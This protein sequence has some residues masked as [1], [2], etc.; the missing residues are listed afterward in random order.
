MRKVRQL[1]ESLLGWGG[2]K[3]VQD[4]IYLDNRVV[5]MRG[6]RTTTNV[7]ESG[8]FYV[9]K[10][11]NNN[12]EY[13]YYSKSRTPDVGDIVF[14]G[15]GA[16]NYVYEYNS[17]NDYIKSS[18]G[19]TYF[20]NG[21]DD[22][23][24]FSVGLT[25]E[26]V[27]LINI[28]GTQSDKAFTITIDYNNIV[29]NERFFF[30]KQTQCLIRTACEEVGP[31]FPSV[32]TTYTLKRIV[33]D[34]YDPNT[35]E[36]L[37]HQFVAGYSSKNLINDDY[38]FYNCAQGFYTYYCNGVKNAATSE[39]SGIAHPAKLFI[40]CPRYHRV[41]DVNIGSVVSIENP[42]PTYLPVDP[43]IFSGDSRDQCFG[44]YNQSFNLDN[45][46]N[47]VCG[48]YS[49]HYLGSF[50]DPVNQVFYSLIINLE[51][52]PI[53]VEIKSTITLGSNAPGRTY[54]STEKYPMGPFTTQTSYYLISTNVYDNIVT[55]RDELEWVDFDSGEFQFNYGYD[56][57]YLSG[58]TSLGILPDDNM[59]GSAYSAT[60][61]PLITNGTWDGRFKSI[62]SLIGSGYAN[63][64]I[65][66]TGA[67]FS[68]PVSSSSNIPR[69]YTGPKRI[70]TPT[71]ITTAGELA[72]LNG[73]TVYKE[74]DDPCYVMLIWFHSRN[75][76]MLSICLVSE[77][78]NGAAY[79]TSSSS[80]VVMPSESMLHNEKRYYFNDLTI[81]A[82]NWPTLVNTKDI[83]N[84][85]LNSLVGAY[86]SRDLVRLVL[87]WYDEHISYSAPII[88]ADY[89]NDGNA[90]MLYKYIDDCT[91][92]KNI[93]VYDSVTGDAVSSRIYNELKT[94]PESESHIIL[95]STYDVS[96]KARYVTLIGV[97]SGT[98]HSLELNSTKI[99]CNTNTAYFSD[100]MPQ[101]GGLPYLEGGFAIPPVA[102]ADGDLK[103]DYIVLP[104]NFY[105]W[106][107]TINNVTYFIFTNSLDAEEVVYTSY[108]VKDTNNNFER[109]IMSNDTEITSLTS[110]YVTTRSG[111]EYL[112]ASQYDWALR[113]ASQT[114]VPVNL[115]GWGA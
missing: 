41:F 8:N 30:D 91:N 2:Y 60:V 54:Y 45:L 77:T 97:D 80:T 51:T 27:Y 72:V 93:T 104:D 35:G 69:L 103:S 112:R 12:T 5:Y 89:Y 61:M 46:T 82:S 105:A 3:D 43:P 10:A 23:L 40:Y 96:S 48:L 100:N 102:I 107:R 90:G 68:T 14:S 50:S 13:Y 59:I 18:N 55:Y 111:I 95:T 28:D 42:I 56:S 20:F 15:L 79:H 4:K 81:T 21:E 86:G 7:T 108:F 74:Y 33:F 63:K 17:Q 44:V 101:P 75:N 76:Y 31:K 92:I 62:A 52:N 19:Y 94:I 9:W 1:K 88:M 6:T 26:K 73:T 57:T 109:E 113:Y 114:Y 11:I 98:D 37:D 38:R 106:K 110:D 25:T 65:N 67:P 84:I 64:T 70:T 49:P 85:T 58:G 83:T 22:T 47:L 34:M 16:R 66:Y 24:S 29:L 87:G 115:R 36:L 32:S 71:L 53:S 39:D 99:D 78:E